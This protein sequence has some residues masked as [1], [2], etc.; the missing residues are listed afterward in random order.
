MNKVAVVLFN[1][2]GPLKAQDVKPFLFNLF[3]DR[4]IIN[5]P[6][7]FRWILACFISTIRNK[8]S[9]KI[10]KS[11]GGGSPLLKFTECQAVALEKTLGKNF[12]V[13]VSMRY[14]HPFSGEVVKKVEQYDPEKIILL[15]L[16]PQF[17]TTTTNSSLVDF[18]KK[19]K[20]SDIL[21]NKPTLSICCF[22]N[23]KKI[24]RSTSSSF[25]RRVEKNSCKRKCSGLVFCSRLTIVCN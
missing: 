21:F 10:Y 13:F 22:F 11:L 6:N 12:K 15:P 5:M 17:S 9:Q 14:W 23:N 18:Q 25:A 4:A 20:E 3:Y 1:L 19:I 16:Y 8:K 7:P 24:Y 2:G